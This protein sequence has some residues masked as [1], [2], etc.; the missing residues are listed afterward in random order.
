M[1]LGERE[2]YKSSASLEQAVPKSLWN[3]CPSLEAFNTQLEKSLTDL[4]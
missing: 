4:F 1:G 3:I 2:H